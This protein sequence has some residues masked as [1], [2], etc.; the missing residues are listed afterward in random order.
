MAVMWTPVE[1]RN[2]APPITFFVH[3]GTGYCLVWPVQK[4]N[5]EG[6]QIVPYRGKLLHKGHLAVREKIDVSQAVILQGLNFVIFC[7]LDIF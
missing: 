1:H 2:N 6:F 3:A 7:E 4:L 5:T